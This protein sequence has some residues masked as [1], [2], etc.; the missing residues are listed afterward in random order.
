MRHSVDLTKEHCPMT[1]V[2][3]KVQLAKLP[4]G[5]ELEVIVHGKEPGEN[6]PRSAA[7]Q[8][9]LVHEVRQEGERYHIIVSKS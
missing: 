2:K 6:V 7:E 8:G 5:D 3:A 4:A 9:F 1:Y